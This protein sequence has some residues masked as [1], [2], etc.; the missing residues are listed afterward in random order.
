MA[1][2]NPQAEVRAA[3]LSYSLQLKRSFGVVSDTVWVKAPSDDE[4]ESV[5]PFELERLTDYLKRQTAALK[6]V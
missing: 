6:T 4:L 1:N 2:T 3:W 5:S